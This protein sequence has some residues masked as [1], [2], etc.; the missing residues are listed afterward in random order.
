MMNV[1]F[2]EFDADAVVDDDTS[3]TV[4]LTL[5]KINISIEEMSS[6]ENKLLLEVLRHK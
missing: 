1:E 5:K 4:N 3:V 6:W 2:D